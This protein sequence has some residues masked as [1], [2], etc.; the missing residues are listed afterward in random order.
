ME[1]D[2]SLE[3]L[4]M[5]LSKKLTLSFIFSIIISIFIISFISNTMINNKFDVY[6]IEE[7]N[8]KFEKI[9]NDINDLFIKKGDNL[10][11]NDISNY[12]S[13]EGI[14]IE[15]K[16]P[17]NNMICHS[18]NSNKLH[19]GMMGNMMRRHHRMMNP[20][21]NNIGNYVEKTFSLL[22]ENKVIGTLV[23]GYI[24]NSHLTESAMIFKDTLSTSFFISGIITI[25][26]GFIVSVFLSK[27]LANPLVNITNTAN[28]I[29]NGNLESRSTVKTNT[30][31]IFQL[32]HS[33]NC[34]A[35][36]LE[37]QE[38]LRK[39]YA[40]DIAHELR[41]PLTTLKSHVEAMLDGI[42]EPND[43]HLII[44]MGEIDRLTKLVE[45]LKNTFK[46]LEGQLNVKKTKFNISTELKNIVS[47]FEPLFNQKNYILESSIEEDVEIFMDKDRLKQ[48]MYNL[49]SN[50]MKYLK[51]NG[52]VFVTLNKEKNNIKI[53]V[54][55]NGTGIKKEDLPFVFDRFYRADISR[56]KETG[57]T[58]LGLS[59]TKS[60][61][62]THGGSITVDSEFGKGT[63]FTIFMP[64]TLLK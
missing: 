35:E 17:Q 31:E 44:L 33:I 48:I 63:K 58:G 19:K 16:D 28:Q 30:K 51:D 60:L 64:I 59:I 22:D 38:N 43:E 52:K 14:Y 62:E 41:T 32:S 9:R 39:R 25:I 53:T 27:G 4:N 46:T 56:N 61:V 50:A 23:I 49:L 45:D 29:R 26:L 6:L 20:N 13:M 8:K 3:V 54:K 37:K 15:I 57:G 11:S 40:L 47:G 55:D 12:A 1:P 24:D 18:N 36:T 42:W 5:S 7:Q 34:L 2:I 10:T 21:F